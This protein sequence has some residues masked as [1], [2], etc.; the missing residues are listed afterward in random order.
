MGTQKENKRGQWVQ[1]NTQPD[2]WTVHTD[3]RGRGGVGASA[4][5]LVHPVCCS[6]QEGQWSVDGLEPPP[7]TSWLLFPG[8]AATLSAAVQK[9]TWT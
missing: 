8:V 4:G 1:R 6:H 5:Q 7:S 9:G 3:R 2:S